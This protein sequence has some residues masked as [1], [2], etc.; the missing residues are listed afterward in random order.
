MFSNFCRTN[1]RIWKNSLSCAEFDSLSIDV[2]GKKFKCVF[3]MESDTFLMKT[4]VFDMIFGKKG[5]EYLQDTFLQLLTTSK[6]FVKTYV[7]Y[8]AFD[9][10]SSG[11]V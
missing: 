8:A 9:A 6:S 5:F 2:L 10:R 11:I 1:L 4:E 3:D 7:I